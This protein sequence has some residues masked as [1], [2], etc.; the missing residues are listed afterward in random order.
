MLE[1]MNM[2]NG[3]EF[4]NSSIRLALSMN[5]YESNNKWIVNIG[6]KLR[7]TFGKYKNELN[8]VAY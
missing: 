8:E 6:K 2:N 5:D 4:L 7:L 1:T 3:H